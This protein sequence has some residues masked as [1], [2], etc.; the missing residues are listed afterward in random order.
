MPTGPAAEQRKIDNIR[1]RIAHSNARSLVPSV[2]N[3]ISAL[4][5]WSID[6]LCVSE[7][8]LSSQVNS[9]FLIFPGYKIIRQDRERDKIS[10]RGGGVC[11]I[12]REELRVEKVTALKN[13]SSLESTWISVCCKNTIL[14]GIIY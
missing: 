11:I 10:G 3:V 14:V 1:L 2:D 12:Y 13:S 7:T 4:S 9:D 5:A 8:W 6:I